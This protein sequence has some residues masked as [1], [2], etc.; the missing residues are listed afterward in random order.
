[1]ENHP[2]LVQIKTSP[3][4][5]KTK[6][7][8]QQVRERLSAATGKKYW[9][10]LEE[11]IDEPGFEELLENEFPAG[12][13]ELSRAEDGLSRRNF[14]KL[15]GASMA[16]AGLS[17]CTRQPAE[18]IVPYIRQPEDLI[19]GIPKFFATT[20]P[21]P[22]GGIP[23]L[24][25]SNEFRPTKIE[26]NPQHPASNG[27]T[28]VFAQASVLDLYDPDRSTSSS[29]RGEQRN[30]GD[31]AEAIDVY[32]TK[33]AGS[34]GAGLR[35][36]S[37]TVISP[38]LASQ[39]QTVLKKFPSAKWYQWDPV[40]RDAAR[41]ASQ[42][43]FGQYAEPIYKFEAANV[44]LSL[45]AD[46]LNTSAFPGFIPYSRAFTS[47][48]KLAEDAPMSRL[49]AVES[50]HTTA[51]ALSDNRLPLRA[52]DIL[53]FAAALA[54]AL[55]VAGVSAPS[56]EW[57]QD[58]Q[59][60]LSALAKDLKAN[61]G[62]SI[63]LPGEQQPPELHILAAQINQALGN[64]GKTIVYADPVEL[65][66]SD[67]LGGLKQLVAD[68]NAGKVDL[69]VILEGNPAYNT[70]VDLGFELAMPKVKEIVHLCNYRNETTRMAEW[71]LHGAHYLEMW[72]DAR[73]YDGTASIVQPLITLHRHTRV[74]ALRR[75]PRLLEAKWESC[76][77]LRDQLAQ[78]AARR[79]H[80]QY[81]ITGEDSCSARW[82]AC[83]QDTRQERDRSRLPSRS[84]DLRRTLQQQR[85][86][87]G[88]SQAADSSGVGQRRDDEH[89]YRGQAW[90]EP[91]R[92]S[93]H[94]RRRPHH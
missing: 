81:C 4:P 37:E 20:M 38:T 9:R 66:P 62:A 56:Q 15:A 32:K 6:L 17:A 7:T 13:A 61:G 51:G 27:A 8:L 64:I 12:V 30:W 84:H 73:A 31:F 55:G 14:L 82:G 35:F 93:A 24:V 2:E 85:L 49:Y 28:D 52:S 48:R 47:R 90:L 79:H 46:F 1:M 40:N 72:S 54:G 42:T 87:A 92:H 33:A 69:L 34:G 88:V 44:V 57:T 41:A 3:T 45:D 65:V 59:K 80:S 18:A 22:T 25:K 29:Y 5:H 68:M 63:V 16:L 86:A 53:S 78:V 83:R 10:S 26:G 94:H 76:R 60:F 43:L 74:N 21:F 75:G 36:L 23:L 70:P 67:Q 39:I 91:G 77:R 19:P 58:Q 50:F 71:H 11:L 89:R